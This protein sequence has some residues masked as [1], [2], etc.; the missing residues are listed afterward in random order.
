MDFSLK[1]TAITLGK[2]LVGLLLLVFVIIG[3]ALNFVFTPEKI[4][5]KVVEAINKNLNAE[6]HAESIELSFFK[7]FPN[8]TLEVAHGSI[9]NHL[10]DMVQNKAILRRDSLV[11]FN[12]CLLSVNPWA[13][14]RNKI[15]VDQLVIEKPQ[16]YAYISPE[17]NVNW[18]ILKNTDSIKTE[19]EKTQEKSDFEANIDIRDV[20]IKD[21]YVFFE[22]SLTDLFSSLEG[23]ELGLKAKYNPEKILLDLDCRSESSHIFKQGDSLLHDFG[24]GIVSKLE[25]DRLTKALHT[26]KTGLII[27]DAAFVVSGDVLLHQEKKV[28]ELDLVFGLENASLENLLGLIPASMID[29]KTLPQTKGDIDL[30]GKVKGDYGKEIYPAIDVALKIKNGEIAYQGRPNKLDK[31]QADLNVFID[32]LNTEKS[33]LK[34]DNCE[35]LGKNTSIKIKALASNILGNTSLDANLDGKIDL[36]ELQKTIPF[37]EGIRLKGNFDSK[38]EI[39]FTKEDI[40]NSNYGN[41]QGNGFFTLEDFVAE[42]KL[43]NNLFGTGNSKIE[44][45]QKENSKFL[46]EAGVKV[47]GGRIN[48]SDLIIHRNSHLQLSSER[49]LLEYGAIPVK[50][51]LS[52]RRVKSNFEIRKA[53]LQMGDSVR[54]RITWAKGDL[55]I[56]PSK[57]NATMPSFQTKMQIDS[58]GIQSKSNY[59]GI[60]KGSYNLSTEKNEKNLWPLDGELTFESLVLYASSFPLEIKMPE[61]KIKLEEGEIRL[62]KAHLNLGRSDFT[63]TGK[64]YNFGGRFFRDELMKGDL[65]V[66]SN[67]TDVNQ[68]IKALNAGEKNEKTEEIDPNAQLVTIS[69]VETAD[70]A[71]VF[72]VP[73]GVEF[74]WNTYIEKAEL[75]KLTLKNLKGQVTLK[76]QKLAMN[77]LNM[78]TN[79]AKMF[80]SSTYEAKT[81]ER[82]NLVMD[83][84]LI[85]IDLANLIDMFPVLDSIMPMANSFE[86]N[87]NFRMKGRADMDANL[88]MS[89]NKLEL[90]ARILGKN[91]VIMDSETFRK[92]AKL[93]F[94]KDK[95]RNVIDEMSFAL[96]YKDKA[97]EVFPSEFEVDRYR[98]AVGGVQRLNGNYSFHISVLKT[99]VPLVKMGIDVTGT[100]KGNDFDLTNAKYKYFFAKRDKRRAKADQEL[101]TRKEGV[102][103]RLPFD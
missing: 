27:N 22:N 71:S 81:K 25:V 34:L 85:D 33:F 94:F 93:L 8:F 40:K 14:L 102:I 32:P 99:P 46:N 96:Q 45:I 24:L 42:N 41:I 26:E 65:T 69:E 13:F 82:A 64:L 98:I 78:I 43:K 63:A 60:K 54:S 23:L 50:D 103:K 29:N 53:K 62:E 89:A 6:L 72:V 47:R 49:I 76:D 17:G 57:R 67:F 74:V 83:F 16:I 21:G 75:G 36:G 15:V 4:T 20:Q 52:L 35:I 37:K 88:G 19:S 101:M 18:D 59:F 39:S 48:I 86:G 51:S 100:A 79:G 84:K 68:I 61:T 58:A 12:R 80:T 7:T 66:R 55:F 95:E 97:L 28:L 87:V 5:P 2:I 1:K 73:K 90:I 56:G 10:N 44:F 9:V 3:I 30:N 11:I 77:S 38:L 70:S 91:M 31:L 92:L